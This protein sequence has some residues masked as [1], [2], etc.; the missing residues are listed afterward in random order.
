MVTLGW[1]K[2]LPATNA[3]SKHL[4]TGLKAP[5]RELEQIVEQVKAINRHYKIPAY[6]PQDSPEVVKLVAVI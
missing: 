6:C 3:L 1:N 5:L 2:T 4:K